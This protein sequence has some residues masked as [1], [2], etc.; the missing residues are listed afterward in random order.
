MVEHLR[1][2][3]RGWVWNNERRACQ[4]YRSNWAWKWEPFFAVEWR[5]KY[6][7]VFNWFLKINDLKVSK[8]IDCKKTWP[9]WRRKEWFAFQYFLDFK[10]NEIAHIQ[11]VCFNESIQN[12]DD[13][14]W[15]GTCLLVNLNH[16]DSVHYFVKILIF[17]R[18]C[19][20]VSYCVDCA[21]VSYDVHIHKTWVDELSVFVFTL[22]HDFE[23]LDC[24]D[25]NLT[26]DLFT[27]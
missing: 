22:N 2:K 7:V 15:F 26:C 19:G 16:R 9:S 13:L 4:S 27:W 17:W 14:S 10:I 23:R 3:E 25:V 8:V 20:V 1:F 6:I 5:N 12:V 21:R 24:T 11:R 18:H